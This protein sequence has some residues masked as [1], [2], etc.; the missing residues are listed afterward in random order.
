MTPYH[1]HTK[2][3]ETEVPTVERV[4]I[5][6]VTFRRGAGCCQESPVRIVSAY[7]DTD[8]NLLF[9]DDPMGKAIMEA[10]RS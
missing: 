6:R 8:G 3:T 1:D 2:V 4:E 7:F 9:E 5:V 10:E